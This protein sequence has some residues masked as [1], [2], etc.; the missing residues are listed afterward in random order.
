MTGRDPSRAPR[1]PRNPR[2]AWQ[3]E[4][5]ESWLEADEAE[6]DCDG[7][8]EERQRA[9]QEWAERNAEED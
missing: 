9:E 1:L 4:Y 6:C 5:C 7:A 3:C 8:V 2:G